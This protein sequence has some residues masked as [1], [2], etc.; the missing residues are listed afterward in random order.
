MVRQYLM[1]KSKN[2]K[3]RCEME[4]SKPKSKEDRRQTKR[5]LSNPICSNPS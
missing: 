5:N 1:A 4:S 2:K 3:G